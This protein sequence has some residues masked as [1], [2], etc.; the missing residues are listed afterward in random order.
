MPKAYEVQWCDPTTVEFPA[1]RTCQCDHELR[2]KETKIILSSPNTE[3][4]WL[5]LIE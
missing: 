2:T 1:P 4:S 3:Q 5:A